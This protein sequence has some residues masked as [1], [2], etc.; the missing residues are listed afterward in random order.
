MSNSTKVCCPN[1]SHT[2]KS[3]PENCTC[4]KCGEWYQ[5]WDIVDLDGY[6]RG[7]KISMYGYLL[8]ALL[9]AAC[10]VACWSQNI[11]TL[12]STPGGKG[13]LLVIPLLVFAFI[14]ELIVGKNYALPI[15]FLLISLLFLIPSYLNLRKIQNKNNYKSHK[16]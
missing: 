6:L 15:G 5:N 1:C 14:G 13:N 11:T 7:C 4:P 10:A 12:D 3:K 2:I 16:L 8:V 9:L